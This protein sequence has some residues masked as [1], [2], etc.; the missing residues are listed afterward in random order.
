MIIPNEPSQPIEDVKSQAAETAPPAVPI[1]SLSLEERKSRVFFYIFTAH[2]QM[3]KSLQDFLSSHTIYDVLPM[4]GQVLVFNTEL[5]L[6][7]TISALAE[8]NI[9]C[10]VMWD[11]VNRTFP[12]LFTIRDILEILVFMTEQLE[13][14]YPGKVHT[15]PATDSKLVQDFMIMLQNK[16][17]QAKTPPMEIGE[18]E[19]AAP[20]EKLTSAED[21]SATTGYE[22]LFS[23]LKATKLADWAR[24]SSHIVFF[25]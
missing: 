12:D 8:H 11:E 17:T 18:S 3:K 14:Q 2:K 15:L 21:P 20:T 6:L 10:G 25:L 23:I 9:F 24:L 19:R 22:I 5:S 7:D 16:A 13:L 4:N 1:T